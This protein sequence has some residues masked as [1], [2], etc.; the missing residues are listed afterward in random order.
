MDKRVPTLTDVARSA[1]VSYATVDR[2]VNGRGG[3]AEKSA[4][5]VRAAIDELGYVRNVAAANLSQRRTYLFVALIPTGPNAFFARI[6][7]ILERE[8]ARLRPAQIDLRIADVAAFDARALAAALEALVG[9]R[10]DGVL[11]VGIED[12]SVGASLTAL[13]AAGAAIVTLVSDTPDA[14]HDAYIGIDNRQAGATAAR[15]IGLAHGGRSGRV[16]PIVGALS[17][18]DHADR[19]AGFAATLAGHFPAIELMERVEG[20]DRPDLVE[21]GAA[22]ALAAEPAPTAIYSAG[23]GNAGL[24]R[25]L[26]VRPRGAPRPTVILHELVAHS[27]RALAHG[28]VDIVIDQRPEEEVRRALD[29]LRRIADRHPPPPP[30]PVPI[31]PA[32]HVAENLPPEHPGE[33]EG[34]PRP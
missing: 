11:V 12:P 32:I 31:V 18:R 34:E 7:A 17:A 4:R 15:L 21:A 22:A 19:L 9:E 28:L 6:R 27:R 2:V 24:I 1:G 29:C 26:A 3:V 8:R 10:P 16:L 13:R 5:R 14:P 23:A 20:R 30:L 25:A 33:L